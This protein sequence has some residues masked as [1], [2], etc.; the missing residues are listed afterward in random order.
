LAGKSSKNI[1][2]AL[3]RFQWGTNSGSVISIRAILYEQGK[4][5]KILHPK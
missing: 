5:T 3:K 4:V 2:R 1:L